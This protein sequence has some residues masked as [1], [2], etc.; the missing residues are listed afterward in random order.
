[1]SYQKCG[2]DLLINSEKLVAQ[3]SL[4]KDTHINFHDR[5]LENLGLHMDIGLSD[6][7]TPKFEPSIVLPTHPDVQFAPMISS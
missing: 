6:L 2:V 1:M 4:E 7:T 3:Q 5:R